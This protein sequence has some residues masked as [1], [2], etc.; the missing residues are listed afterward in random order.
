MKY[1]IKPEITDDY[2]IEHYGFEKMR[3]HDHFNLRATTDEYGL[4]LEV[5]W[6]DRNIRII[7]GEHGEYGVAPIP[8]LLIQM[9]D[10]GVI[11]KKEE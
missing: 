10:D 7:L 4:G 11:F 1:Y 6:S 8:P 3:W 9:Y 5:W 2:L